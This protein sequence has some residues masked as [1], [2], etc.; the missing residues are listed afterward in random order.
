[1]VYQA[2][3]ESGRFKEISMIRAM[4]KCSFVVSHEWL[5]LYRI[6]DILVVLSEVLPFNRVANVKFCKGVISMPVISTGYSTSILVLCLN[7]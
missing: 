6:N 4:N 5:Q 2:N 1:M 3:K 7:E